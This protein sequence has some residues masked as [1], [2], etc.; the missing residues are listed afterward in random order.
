MKRKI[1]IF[2]T[3]LLALNCMYIKA[4]QLPVF[5]AVE[6]AGIE[7]YDSER[8]IK[9]LK[10]LDEP[11]KNQV[12]RHIQ[13]FNQEMDNI[14]LLHSDTLKD[15]ENEFDRNVRIAMQNRDR[16]QMNGV[17]SKIEKIIPPIRLEVQKFKKQLNIELNKILNEKQYK[18]WL[19]IR[20]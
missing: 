18:K 19:K 6:K 2:V 17:K 8:I 10:I 5:N 16:S 14:L 3:A 13:I 4:Q 11:L 20:K 9:K 1:Q 15:L 7:K 12:T